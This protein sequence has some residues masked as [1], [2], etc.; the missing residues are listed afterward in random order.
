MTS[1]I[2]VFELLLLTKVYLADGVRAC[3]RYEAETL[4]WQKIAATSGRMMGVS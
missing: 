3:D 4:L 1:N 2:F